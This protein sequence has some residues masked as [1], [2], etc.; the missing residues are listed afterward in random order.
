LHFIPTSSSWLN[1]IER[2]F[3]ELTG[4]RIRRGVFHSVPD[5]ISAIEEYLAAYNENA[6]PFVW[7]A[8]VEKIMEKIARARA[9]LQTTQ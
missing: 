2:W 3:R 6:K 7:T 1:L 5:L 4:K 8:E 9:A